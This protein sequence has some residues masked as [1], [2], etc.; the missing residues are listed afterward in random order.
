MRPKIC[1]YLFVIDLVQGGFRH[2]L[3]G[4]QSNK[5]SKPQICLSPSLI[6]F[7]HPPPSAAGGKIL[8][9]IFLDEFIGRN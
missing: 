2:F 7:R 6:F 8:K 1:A 3:R 5:Q 9:T 4:G